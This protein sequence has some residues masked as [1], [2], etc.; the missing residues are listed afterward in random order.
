MARI[1][2]QVEDVGMEGAETLRYVADQMDLGYTSG[3]YPTWTIVY[4]GN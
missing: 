1:E 2:I 3:Y 4:G